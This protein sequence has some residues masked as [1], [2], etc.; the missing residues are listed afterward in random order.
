MSD[1]TVSG[2]IAVV[3]NA[4]A[5]VAA[6]IELF[7]R[8]F[9]VGPLG[10]L[11]VVIALIVSRSPTRLSAVAAGCVGVGFVIGASIAVWNTHALY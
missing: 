8:P 11:L 9:G 1:G 7:Y 4:L 2:W 6:V 5:I 3:L 10:L